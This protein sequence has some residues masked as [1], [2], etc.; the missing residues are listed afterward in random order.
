MSKIKSFT[1]PFIR[2]NVSSK[3]L[4]IDVLIALIPP[5]AWGTYVY[6]ARSLT[7]TLLSVLGAVLSQLLW[8][9]CTKTKQN[10][11]SSVIT[12]VIVALLC[13]TSVPLWLAP[14]GSAFGVVVGKMLFGGVGRNVFN[15]SALGV[16]FL[17][18]AFP[19]KMN[20]FVPLFEK[21]SAFELDPILAETAESPLVA[22]KSG[23]MD[24]SNVW[25][26]IYGMICGNIGELSAVMLI[27]AWVYLFV[28]KTVKWEKTISYIAGMV[29]FVALYCYLV[30][31]LE[32]F[33]YA[34]AQVFSGS[35]VFVAVYMCNDYSTT[36]TTSNGGIFFGVVCAFIT[37]VIRVFCDTLDGAVFAVLLTN[38]L[39]P[40]LERKTR[41]MYFGQMFKDRE[42]RV[43]NNESK[44]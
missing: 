24:V 32:P 5:L 37:T 43:K 21:I 6:G 29:F 23:M 3:G 22:L 10:D 30:G 28:R 12:G 38:V 26:K 44:Q 33:Q 25:E 19:E 11:I 7:I 16:V 42:A 40:L 14:L 9:V 35:T 41:P 27:L 13:P 8:C 1:A 36:P 4:M 20:T 2:D 15:P 17:H 18:V 34:F 39:V 31:M